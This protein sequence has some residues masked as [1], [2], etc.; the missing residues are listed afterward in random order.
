MFKNFKNHTYYY[1]SLLLILLFGF[2]LAFFSADKQFQM[3]VIVLT[4][5]CYVGW[6]IL[7]HY[8]YH[9]LSV[10]I[11]VEYILVGTLGATVIFFILKGGFNL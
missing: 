1:I 3:L 8:L 9:E 6:G 2:L 7:H 4:S 10:K 11:M 5:F